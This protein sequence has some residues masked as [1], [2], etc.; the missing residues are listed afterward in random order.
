VLEQDAAGIVK[1]V[2]FDP[3]HDRRAGPRYVTVAVGRDYGDVP[4]TSGTFE[5]PFPGELTTHKT[6]AVVRVEYLQPPRR[7]RRVQRS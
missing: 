1:A 3:T 4:P 2:P 5:G 6:A 7:R